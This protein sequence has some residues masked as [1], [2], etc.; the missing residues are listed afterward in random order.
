MRELLYV[1]RVDTVGVEALMMQLPAL[2]YRPIGVQV[3]EDV[4]IPAS[5]VM[6]ALTVTG[7]CQGF[8]E[9]TPTVGLQLLVVG[10]ILVDILPELRD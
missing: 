3:A 5:A 8:A 2:S 1:G 6:D 7:F 9:P 4:G 10:T